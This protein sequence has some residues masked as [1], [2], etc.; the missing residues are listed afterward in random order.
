ML[1]YSLDRIIYG[2]DNAY[3]DAGDGDAVLLLQ[4]LAPKLE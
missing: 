2:G 3:D 1:G 4:P